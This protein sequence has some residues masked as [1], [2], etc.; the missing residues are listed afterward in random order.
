MYNEI[1]VRIDLPLLYIK[2]IQQGYKRMSVKRMVEY[3]ISRLK[4]KR[5]DIRLEAIAELILLD[6]TEALPELETVYHND[7]NADVR[8]A[9]KDAGKK[10]FALQVLREK[11]E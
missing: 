7:T 6:A 4:D 3:H 9:A 11:Q 1:I 10:L 2:V 8:R 5:D